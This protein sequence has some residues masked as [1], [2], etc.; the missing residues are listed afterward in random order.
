MAGL[1]WLVQL[2]HYPLMLEIGPERFSRWHQGHLRRVTW[3]VG[4]LMLV[5]TATG[6]WWIAQTHPSGS[7]WAPWVGMGLILVVWIST[8]ALQIPAHRRLELGG[9]HPAHIQSLVRSNWVRTVAWTMRAA[10][11]GS[12]L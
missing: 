9:Y 12:Q 8:A 3:V 2:A 4:P 5:E 1:I 7:V 6:L 10:L 11:V